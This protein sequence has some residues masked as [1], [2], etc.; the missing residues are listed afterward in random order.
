MQDVGKD[1]EGGKTVGSV[2][3]MQDHGESRRGCKI[4]GI[5][6]DARCWEGWRGRQDDLER[7]GD[8]R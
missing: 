8:A 7:E 2:K 6:E 3:G 4:M 5:V 1:G